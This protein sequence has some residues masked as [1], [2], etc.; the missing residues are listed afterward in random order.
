MFYRPTTISE[1]SPMA[2]DSGGAQYLCA[3]ILFVGRLYRN[4]EYLSLYQLT[5]SRNFCYWAGG[6]KQERIS[7]S[8]LLERFGTQFV[9]FK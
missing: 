4:V 7:N 1:I 5:L 2:G 6:V 3:H 8:R 9:C